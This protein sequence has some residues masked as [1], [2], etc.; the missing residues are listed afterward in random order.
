MNKVY[1]CRVCGISGPLG[2]RKGKL[3]PRWEGADGDDDE[4]E[5]AKEKGSG[6]ESGDDGD[7]DDKAAGSAK[8]TQVSTRKLLGR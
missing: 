8:K 2:T 4:A 7:D 5:E 3:A 1:T 6:D